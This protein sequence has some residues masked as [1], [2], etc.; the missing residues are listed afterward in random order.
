M[1]YHYTVVSE[2]EKM[3]VRFD[4]E[5]LDEYD[6]I[7][8]SDGFAHNAM[9]VITADDPDKIQAYNWGLIPHWVKTEADAQQL[10]ARTLNA[11]GE[12][13]FDLPSF[14]MYVPKKRCL[15]LADGF[16]EWM[17]VGKNKYPHFIYMKDRQPFAFAGIYSHWKNPVTEQVFKTYSILTTEA[18]GMMSKIHNTKKRM[19]VI[20]RPDM[21]KLWLKPDLMKDEIK[22]LIQP[23]EDELMEAHTISRL[24]TSRKESSNQP[25]I[26]DV[27]EYPELAMVN[28]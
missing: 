27:C 14:K 19:P 7:Y 23:M 21:E 11:K 3:A 10:R 5:I 1:C 17:H 26:M 16:F 28:Q 15:V 24:I 25:K 13:V 12:T 9:P 20:L 2:P 6:A 4:A 8:H 18:N 22:N